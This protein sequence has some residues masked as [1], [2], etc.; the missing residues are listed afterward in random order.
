MRVS[1]PR[2]LPTIIRIFLFGSL[3]S[4]AMI[5]PTPN[6][7]RA[8]TEW[9]PIPTMDFDK[10]EAFL[11]LSEK[12]RQVSLMEQSKGLL[13][14]LPLL[15][16]SE[17]ALLEGYKNAYAAVVLNADRD[18]I[19]AWEQK[20]KALFES[21]GFVPALQLHVQYLIA[22]LTK[23]MGDDEAALALTQKWI[24][25]FLGTGPNFKTVAQQAL[26]TESVSQS[27]F[28]RAPLDALTP[29]QR[30]VTYI[31]PTGPRPPKTS[32][33]T[34]GRVKTPVG[35]LA[36]LKQW[37]VGPLVNIPEVHRVNVIGHFRNNKNPKLFEEWKRNLSLEQEMAERRGL[38]E[39][40]IMN[41]RPWILWQTGKDYAL[42]GRPGEAANIMVVAIKE[43]PRCADY[44][45]IVADIR[46]IIAEFKK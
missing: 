34:L 24:L 41:R 39:S 30:H 29:K 26:L 21:D 13:N 32:S 3:I 18:K 45:K 36:E 44:D 11:Q 20:N 37:Y 33:G 28:L 12:N 27:L 40:F 7:L 25:D 15:L 2:P 16:A 46:R 8:Q 17:S 35:M 10:I 19:Q 6:I 5:L 23:I 1:R 4:L 31:T 38:L 22:T 42:F 43:S 9:S 14:Q